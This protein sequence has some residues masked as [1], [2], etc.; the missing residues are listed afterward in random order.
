MKDVKRFKEK[1][2]RKLNLGLNWMDLDLDLDP[3]WRLGFL[4]SSFTFS[5]AWK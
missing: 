5:L 1:R 3:S 4:M 2:G